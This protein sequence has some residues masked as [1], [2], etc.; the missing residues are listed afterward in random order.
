MA[1][2]EKFTVILAIISRDPEH[3]EQQ[4]KVRERAEALAADFG[5]RVSYLTLDPKV[6]PAHRQILEQVART[7]PDQVIKCPSGQASSQPYSLGEEDWQL[8][9]ECPVPLL[10]VR[11][12]AWGSPVRMAAAV[13]VSDD[14]HTDLARG[15]LH[16]AGF[17]ALGMR[18]RLDVMYSEAE[19]HDEPARL[20]RAVKLARMVREFHVGC[21]RI[22]IIS[23][24]PGQRLPPLLAARRYGLVVLGGR[25]RRRGWARLARGTMSRLMEASDSDLLLVNASRSVAAESGLSLRAAN[26]PAPAARLN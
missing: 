22:Q 4:F 23:G 13:D 2:V 3:A 16:A 24:E 20:A 6:A 9:D 8:A 12:Q 26:E 5:A 10:L 11:G 14:E 18:G 19:I 21:E 1:V 15:I 7:A 17:F 25:S